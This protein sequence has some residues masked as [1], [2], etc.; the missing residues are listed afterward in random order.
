MSVPLSE[1]K[2]TNLYYEDGRWRIAGSGLYTHCP[3]VYVSEK[4]AASIINVASADGLIRRDHHVNGVRVVEFEYSPNNFSDL[5]KKKERRELE[6]ALATE[7]SLAA[8]HLRRGGANA[9]R[10]NAAV[11]KANSYRALRNGRRERV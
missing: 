11:S 2:M 5:L 10:Y 7:I 3:R 9:R 1:F 4:T 6:K 8:E